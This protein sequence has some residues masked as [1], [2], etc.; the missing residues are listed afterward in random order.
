MPRSHTA[1]SSVRV[2]RSATLASVH[3]AE[4]TAWASHVLGWWGQSQHVPLVAGH[5]FSTQSER[6]MCLD[7]TLQ[8][9]LCAACRLAGLEAARMTWRPLLSKGTPQSDGDNHKTF[10]WVPAVIPDASNLGCHVENCTNRA[11]ADSATLGPLPADEWLGL[12]HKIDT[13]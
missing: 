2:V 5:L 6:P 13:L 8:R 4:G 10:L 9:H 12:L 3:N 11:S 7:P 1:G